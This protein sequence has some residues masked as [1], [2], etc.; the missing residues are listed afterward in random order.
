M[1]QP[2]VVLFAPLPTGVVTHMIET[3]LISTRIKDLQGRAEAL[4]GYL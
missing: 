1:H 3:G 2:H 4:R